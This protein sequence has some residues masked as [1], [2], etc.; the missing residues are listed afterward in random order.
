MKV[1]VTEGRA[2]EGGVLTVSAGQ[3]DDQ[4]RWQPQE[5]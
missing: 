2:G 1:E 4:K 5:Y 3:R